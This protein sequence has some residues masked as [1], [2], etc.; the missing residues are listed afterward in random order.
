MVTVKLAVSPALMV[1]LP[2]TLVTPTFGQRT[3]TEPVSKSVGWL[4]LPVI[5]AVLVYVSQ[6][7]AGV[8]VLV[9]VTWKLSPGA[10]TSFWQSRTCGVA[11]FSASNGET[12]HG[13][14]WPFVPTVS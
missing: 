9:T 7:A 6:A 8:L 12:P 11:G 2:G 14:G 10:S 3:S 4:S 5:V 13:S 1:A